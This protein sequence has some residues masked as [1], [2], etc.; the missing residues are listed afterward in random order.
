MDYF[1]LAALV[2]SESLYRVRIGDY[3][4]IY[5]IQDKTLLIIITKVGHRRDI[6]K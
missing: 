4:I 2:T 3:R 6:Y 5:E 1:R